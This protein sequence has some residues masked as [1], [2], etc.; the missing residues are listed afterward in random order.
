MALVVT[1][2]LGI[3]V[4]KYSYYCI[5]TCFQ[6]ISLFKQQLSFRISWQQ[7]VVDKIV[8]RV[9]YKLNKISILFIVIIERFA[10]KIYLYLVVETV[11]P[12]SVIRECKV[13]QT[14]QRIYCSVI[15]NQCVYK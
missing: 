5:V 15:G 12:D 3:S 7:Y 13:F 14:E 11:F 8:S 6:Y 1:R 4:R 10:E 2:R 9:Y